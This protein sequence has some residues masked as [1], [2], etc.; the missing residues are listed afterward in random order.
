MQDVPINMRDIALTPTGAAKSGY[1]SPDLPK[2]KTK[3][4]GRI[5]HANE[6]RVGT[7]D[8][9]FSHF[10]NDDVAEESSSLNTDKSIK[11]QIDRG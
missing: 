8:G 10:A 11:K 7:N 3:L 6:N 5:T 4:S 1:E 2:S 9:R